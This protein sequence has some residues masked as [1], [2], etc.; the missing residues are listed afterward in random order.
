MD[1]HRS[2][3]P[4]SSTHVLATCT[5][6]SRLVTNPATPPTAL[7]RQDVTLSTETGAPPYSFVNPASVTAF[8]EGVSWYNGH[9]WG[10][11]HNFKFGLDISTNHNGYNYTADMGINALYNNGVPIEVIAYNTPVDVSSIY[12]ETAAYAQDSVTL[13]RKL[14]LNLGVRY[15]HFNTFYPNADQPCG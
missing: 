3:Q 8:A 5:R 11:A 6:S 14:T 1:Q 7:N 12:H 13:K 4:G 9:L 15:D 10:A 2:K